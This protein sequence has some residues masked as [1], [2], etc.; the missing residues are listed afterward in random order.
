M[1]KKWP[2]NL[3]LRYR[4][5]SRNLRHMDDGEDDDGEKLRRRRQ[6]TSLRKSFEEDLLGRSLGRVTVMS[7]EFQGGN[8]FAG[9]Q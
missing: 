3:G 5:R 4:N 6:R 8:S 9:C 7:D 2:K 1:L